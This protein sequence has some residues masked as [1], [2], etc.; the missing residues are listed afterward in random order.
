MPR[1]G[2]LQVVTGQPFIV[3][4]GIAIPIGVIAAVRRYSFFDYAIMVGTT[5]GVA[6]PNFWVGLMLIVIFALV[7][8]WLPP[9]GLPVP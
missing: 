1:P 8:H 5:L 3:S 4:V 2:P 6:L 9:Y 7:L